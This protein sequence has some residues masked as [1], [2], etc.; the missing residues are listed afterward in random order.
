M[1]YMTDGITMNTGGGCT[2]IRHIGQ[3]IVYKKKMPTPPPL[4]QLIQSEGQVSWKEMYNVFN[5]GIGLDIV[6][7]NHPV[8]IGILQ[9]ACRDFRLPEPQWLGFCHESADGNNKVILAT[10]YGTF[11]Y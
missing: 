4:F 7:D 9:E 3:G 11:E 5:C 6:A 8:V 1:M 10:E 2:K